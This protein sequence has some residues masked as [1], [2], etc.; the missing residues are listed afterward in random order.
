MLPRV[1]IDPDA[2]FCMGVR[3]AIQMAED[4]LKSEAVLYCLGQPVHNEAEVERLARLGLQVIS[5][6]DLDQI[7]GDMLMIRAHG[8][9]PNTYKLLKDN[10]IRYLDASCP[11]VIKLQDRI[12]SQQYF[13]LQEG[14]QIAVYGKK[15]HPEVLGLSGQ[16][17]NQLL[18]LEGPEDIVQIDVNRP[19]QLFC[20][21]TQDAEAYALMSEL[22]RQHYNR[23]SEEQRPLLVI[24]PSTC[25]QIAGRRSRL[26]TFASSMDVILF[27]SGRESSNGRYL[28]DVCK[29]VNP[30]AYFIG[31]P[32][33]ILQ[34]YWEGA[35]T[36]GISGAASTPSWLL[37]GVYQALTGKTY[38]GIS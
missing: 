1:Y 31:G 12:R 36:I 2:G 16:V 7:G 33:D 34:Q 29:S 14:G 22:I 19:L 5:K 11:I 8:E 25:R 32:E 27:V 6:D 23:V 21:T 28:F 4:H 10:S 35:E 15:G 24:H 37:E 30:R 3:R 20:Q 17:D 18:I 9:P 26:E 38:S 13:L